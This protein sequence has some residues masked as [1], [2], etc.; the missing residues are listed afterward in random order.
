MTRKHSVFLIYLTYDS[1][2]ILAVVMGG[3]NKNIFSHLRWQWAQRGLA[4]VNHKLR[5]E[6]AW[7]PIRERIE[8]KKMYHGYSDNPLSENE[9]NKTIKLIYI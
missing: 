3:V 2:N 8:E 6:K 1:V 7:W 5:S 9:E 4:G